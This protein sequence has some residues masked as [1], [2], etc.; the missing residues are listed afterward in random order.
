MQYVSTRGEAPELGF[1]DVL[2]T[3]LARDGGLYVPKSWPQI[4]ADELRGLR[5]RPYQD[6]AFQVV[7]KF[8]GSAIPETDLKQ[9]V[10]EAYATFGHPAVTPLKQMDA[11]QWLLELFHG[12]TLA[13]KDVAMQLLAR[14]MEW[15]LKKRGSHATIVGATSGDTGGAAIDAFK[16]SRNATTI[17][18]HP[19]GRVSDVQRRQMTT[20][21]SPAIHNIAIEGNLDDCQD[22]LKALFNEHAF[23]DRVGLAG[24][25]SINWARIMAQVVYY[26]SSAVALGAPDRKISFCV[27]TGNFGDIFAGYTAKRMGVPIDRLVIATNVNDILDRTLKTGRYEMQGVKPS[28]SPS[29]DIQVS[30]NFERLLFEVCGRD[31]AAIS[32][33]MSGLTQS[34][35]FTIAPKELA[36]IR[37]EFDSFAVGEAETAQTIAQALKST[38]E[39]LDPHS[40][41]GFAAALRAKA[42]TSPMVTL[43]TAH[44]AKFPEAVEKASGVRPHLPQRL[45]HLLNAKERFTI[46]PNSAAAVRDFVLSIKKA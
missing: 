27:P 30:S 36:V 18:L 4:S 21:D 6:V 28:S 43:A 44:P 26:V 45:S 19:N 2:L 32:G 15:S 42:G 7:S 39:L 10:A 16:N 33:L 25:N 24:V 8:T 17:I 40:A 3:G 38:G 12:P 1:E 46:L 34:G 23:L 11:N 20:V 41:T 31:A 35:A 37:E 29:M 9:M 14:L 5:G 13:F 22:I